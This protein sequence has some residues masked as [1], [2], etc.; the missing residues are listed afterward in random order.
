MPAS[1]TGKSRQ[2]P[3]DVEGLAPRPVYLLFGGDEFLVSTNARKLVDRLCPPADQAFGLEIIEGQEATTIGAAA[4][5][6]AACRQAVQTLGFFGGG[7]TVW[8]RDAVMFSQARVRDADGFKAALEPLLSILRGGPGDGV[9]LVVSA[10][11]V[12]KRS[13]FYRTCKETGHVLEYALPEKTYQLEALARETAASRFA[14]QGLAIRPDV[15]D[16]FVAKVGADTRQLAAEV[17]KLAV[18]V[19]GA[20]EVTADDIR[21]VVAPAREASSWDL[22][23]ALGHRNP[24]EAFRLV[25]QLLFQGE[26][27]TAIVSQ[28]EGLFRQLM[29]LRH[30]LDNGW[31]RLKGRGSFQQVEWAD[32]PEVEA[33][34]SRMDRDP[35]TI[36]PWRAGMLAAQAGRYS[37]K[38]ILRIQELL[39]A[40]HAQLVSSMLPA[41]I[42]L[43][44]ALIKLFG[45]S[46]MRSS[47]TG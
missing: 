17:E 41:P 18:Y 45:P 43:D 38:E 39:A 32:R 30:C 2:G 1:A 35:R 29:I 3:P 25:R 27:P 34:L 10:R 20:G 23:D 46:R 12:D 5:V 44:L 26:N 22:Q 24:S 19:G 14:S 8:L 6:I 4:E 16:L 15:L 9:H 36:N 37:R 47:M 33:V 28:L 21:A 7:K 11:G 13:A 42:V 40:A 31:C